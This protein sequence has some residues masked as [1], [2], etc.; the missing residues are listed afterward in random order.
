LSGGEQRRVALAR[1]L[2][3]DPGLVVADEP[4]A[5]LDRANGHLVLDLLKRCAAEHGATVI[6]SS[7]DPDALEAA[8]QVLHLDAP[9]PS[10]ASARGGSS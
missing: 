1:A 2:V 7:H 3:G 5:D 8:D 9:L 6:V 4:T 10:T